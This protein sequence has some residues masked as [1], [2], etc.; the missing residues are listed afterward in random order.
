MPA[1]AS[2]DAIAAER[3]L[4]RGAAASRRQCVLWLTKQRAG[5]V[6]WW[7]MTKRTIS[8][9]STHGLDWKGIGYLT[10]IVSVLF[11]GA[12]ASLKE[13]PPW[14]YFPALA[15]GMITSICGMGFRYKSHVDEQRE[16]KKAQADA[17]RQPRGEDSGRRRRA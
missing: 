4:G 6:V 13:H 17:E 2:R 12:V 10:S 9:P 15:V 3:P 7:R 5:L 16:I 8:V 1:A 11:L 14:W